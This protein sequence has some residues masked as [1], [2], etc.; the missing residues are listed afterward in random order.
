M[1]SPFATLFLLLQERI[2]TAVPEIRHID[3]DL[4]QL[5]FSKLRPSVAF[6]CVLIDFENFTFKDNG[7]NSQSAEGNISIRLA[8]SPYSNSSQSTPTLWKEK[9]LAYYDIEWKLNKAL[10]GWHPNNDAFGNLDR[11]TAGTEGRED[12]LR[13]RKIV[14]E[15]AFEDDSTED[16]LTMVPATLDVHYDD[17]GHDEH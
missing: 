5:E 14:Y 15:I 2:K 1:N 8:F 13:V 6:P 7:D 4:G 9:A 3:Q 17:D 10:H 16:S 11:A 12:D